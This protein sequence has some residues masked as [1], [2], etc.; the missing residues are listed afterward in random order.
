MGATDAASNLYGR[1]DS[2]PR[3]PCVGR[4]RPHDRRRH[5]EPSQAPPPIA[6]RRAPT[7]RRGA[8][9]PPPRRLGCARPARPPTTPPAQVRPPTRGC[10]G[11]ATSRGHR[12]CAPCDDRVRP[13][14]FRIAGLRLVTECP[15]LEV[16]GDSKYGRRVPGARLRR[17][18]HQRRQRPRK[19]SLTE[20]QVLP[21]R[22]RA[23]LAQFFEV[24]GLRL[25]L[26]LGEP[27]FR[28]VIRRY[29]SGHSSRP[30]AS[31]WRAHHRGNAC[32]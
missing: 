5:P 18:H 15:V 7:V 25:A 1:R 3:R 9:A 31:V 12:T 20:I 24:L 26:I 11:R 22:R 17:K 30:A 13:R 6:R 10:R 19:S 14:P 32:R 2:L 28:R 23:A 4:A 8:P 29:G 16:V 27:R 21:V